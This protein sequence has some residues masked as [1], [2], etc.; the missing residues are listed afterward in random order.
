MNVLH[1]GSGWTLT[2]SYELVR[3]RSRAVTLAS[4]KVVVIEK[5]SSGG[6]LPRESREKSWLKMA[7]RG[8]GIFQDP[9]KKRINRFVEHVSAAKI[10]NRRLR[11]WRRRKSLKPLF[12]RTEWYRRRSSL[13]LKL[14]QNLTITS[15]SPLDTQRASLVLLYERT[16]RRFSS[17]RARMYLFEKC[18]PQHSHASELHDHAHGQEAIATTRQHRRKSSLE[19]ASRDSGSFQ[20]AA[21]RCAVDTMGVTSTLFFEICTP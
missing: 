14:D 4:A 11:G 2:G 15:F 3:R 10:W 20:R 16:P 13:R 9:F 21:T 7:L 18:T 5:C 19:D 12:A 1:V 8:M 6:F 17:F